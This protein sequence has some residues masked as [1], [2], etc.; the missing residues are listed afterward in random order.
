MID[1]DSSMNGVNGS[2]TGETGGAASPDRC[3]TVWQD[4]SGHHPATARMKWSRDMNIAVKECY[5]LSK[6]VDESDR[7]VR[8]YRQRRHA[9]WKGGGLPKV[10]EQKL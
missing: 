1:D 2:G 9:V 6:P 4:G 8:G 3:P 5:Y 7:P 10:T